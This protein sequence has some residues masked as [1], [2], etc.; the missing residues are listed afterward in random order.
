MVRRTVHNRPPGSPMWRT[1]NLHGEHA[2]PVV[3]GMGMEA[4]PQP[5]GHTCANI[6]K[7]KPLQAME[8]QSGWGLWGPP[9]HPP[10]RGGGTPPPSP[11]YLGDL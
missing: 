3:E 6:S 8:I 2:S 7:G 10:P 4:D 5:A 1:V 11:D 9:H